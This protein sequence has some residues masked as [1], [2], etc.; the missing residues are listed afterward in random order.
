MTP[1]L[2]K[3][4]AELQDITAALGMPKFAARQIAQWLYDKRIRTLDEM[5]NLSKENRARLADA[6]YDIG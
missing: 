1:L 5:T 3:T 2:G 4:L 6:G